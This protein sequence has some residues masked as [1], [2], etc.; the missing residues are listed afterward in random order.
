MAM[1]R[2]QRRISLIAVSLGVLALALGLAHD[3]RVL[4]RDLDV[5]DHD[6]GPEGVA[7]E[8]QYFPLEREEVPEARPPQDD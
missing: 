6:V 3:P 5:P 8:D 7:P 2:R 1:T 4:G